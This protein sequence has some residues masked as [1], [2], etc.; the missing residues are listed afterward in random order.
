M[1]C[2][3]NKLQK[4]RCRWQT[5]VAEAFT[6]AIPQAC[7]LD[8]NASFGL[9]CFGPQQKEAAPQKPIGWLGCSRPVR[10]STLELLIGLH[11][12]PLEYFVLHEVGQA[13]TIAHNQDSHE[14]GHGSHDPPR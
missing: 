3:V 2:T 9:V 10:L 1:R 5:T 6:S 7:R 4:D 8:K 12:D 13:A 14:C 11:I